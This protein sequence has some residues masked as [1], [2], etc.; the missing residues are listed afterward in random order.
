MEEALVED[1]GHLVDLVLTAEGDAL[2][3]QIL[4]GPV[5]L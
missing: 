4:K 5:Q 2:F 1:I 3:E